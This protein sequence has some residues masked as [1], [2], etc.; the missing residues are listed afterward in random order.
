MMTLN[1]TYNSVLRQNGIFKA[2]GKFYPSLAVTEADFD[3]TKAAVQEAANA[4]SA[5]C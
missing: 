2:P 4:I 1:A 3:Q 5:M